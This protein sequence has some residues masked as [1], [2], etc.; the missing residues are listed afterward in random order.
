MTG[1]RQRR[2][3]RRADGALLVRS[4][5]EL[6]KT[7]ARIP[8]TRCIGGGKRRYFTRGDAELVLAS[9]DRDDPR[10]R[11]RRAYRCPM[12]HGWHLTSRTLAQHRAEQLAAAHSSDSVV[13]DGELHDHTPRPVRGQRADPVRENTRTA[14]ADP[15]R[16]VPTPAEV[17]ARTAALR[18][19]RVEA[20][21]SPVP[22][23]S[24]RNN[25]IAKLLRTAIT[26]LTRIAP[27]RGR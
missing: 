10:R 13:H 3:L 14:P 12:C 26:R 15:A 21:E 23:R 6:R 16:Q 25:R 1:Q 19:R 24:V 27:R 11:E 9:L 20:T 22:P 18:R 2:G 5:A 4:G 17:A 7:R 8:A